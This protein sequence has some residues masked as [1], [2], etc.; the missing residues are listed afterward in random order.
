MQKKQSY[1]IFII[2]DFLFV[3]GSFL[4]MVWY[5][6]ASLRIY[7]P[8]YFRPF[9]AFWITWMLISLLGGKYTLNR[10]K[11][12][13]DLLTP[14]L[15]IAL[16]TVLLISISVYVFDYYHFSRLIVFG[17]ILLSTGLNVLFIIFYY[18]HRKARISDEFSTSIFNPPTEID[19]EHPLLVHGKIEQEDQIKKPKI[20]FLPLLREK[21]LSNNIRLFQFLHSNLAL[22]L[23]DGIRSFVLNTSDNSSVENLEDK[24]QQFLLNLH[25][26]NDHR[27]V[28]K[29]FILINQKLRY[30]GVFVSCADTL[31]IRFDRIFK[32]YPVYFAW[33]CY[34]VDALFRRVF[35]KLPVF[36][37]IYFALT[38]GR[39]RLISK[40]ELLGRLSFCGFDIEAIQEIEGKLYFIA[41]K[42]RLPIEDVVPSY[43][44]LIKMR[45]IGL[46][47]KI[48]YV[49]KFRTMY[50][51][52]EFLQEYIHKN[53]DLE[54]SGKFKEDFRITGWGRIMR[55][56]WLDE[57]PQFIN[58]FRGE[59]GLVGVRALSEHYFSLYPKDLQ[60]LRTKV[61]PG[62]VPPYYAD[63]P[64]SFEEI[65]ESERQYL[66]KKL[67][68]PFSTDI[69]YFY[70]AFVNIVF[71]GARSK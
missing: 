42:K 14:V 40:A 41:I 26:L 57:L 54:A 8:A 12:L 44:P 19:T 68:K 5:K 30:N 45:R 53:Q 4:L 47:G 13:V 59:L 64:D 21:Y 2:F 1:F 23:M 33:F 17:T 36:K 43:G 32:K 56:L 51:Y 27:R 20:P 29:Y 66:E 10:K 67:K 70:T 55:S 7:L 24:S 38:R 60:Q 28:N 46:D 65:L 48:M 58:F 18:L 3:I 39:N 50:P 49:Y 6:P 16:T 71:K 37:E 11:T 35:P 15:R 25:R 31:G 63:M 52:S 61:K 34:S 22:D 69:N 9:L 62:L